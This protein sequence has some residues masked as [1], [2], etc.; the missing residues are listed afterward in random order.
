MWLVG[1]FC[2]IKPEITFY[3]VSRVV[4]A[5]LTVDLLYLAQAYDLMLSYIVKT[6]MFFK[7]MYWCSQ[8]L[9]CI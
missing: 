6:D 5:G 7:L 1:F 2:I 4:S 8:S 9:L 3:A